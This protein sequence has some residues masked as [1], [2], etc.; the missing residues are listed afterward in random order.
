MSE[1]N[2]APPAGDVYDWYTRGMRLLTTGDAAAAALL[3]EHAARAEP[4]SCSVREALARALFDSGD[5]TRACDAFRANVEDSPAD[6]YAH[7]GLGLAHVRMGEL[8][9]AVEHL[10]IAVALR[11]D[12]HHYGTALRSAR[13]ARARAA[14]ARA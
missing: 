9:Q 2:A 5:Y 11:P 7:F 12:N 4:G 3:L 6:D 10:A 1:I 13:A 14:A 8:D